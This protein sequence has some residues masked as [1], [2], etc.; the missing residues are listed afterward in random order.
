MIVPFPKGGGR[1]NGKLRVDLTLAEARIA[2][3]SASDPKVISD[4]EAAIRTV[5]K[6][7]VV[8]ALS[9]AIKI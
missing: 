4:L 8:I 7:K 1:L 2:V 3:K 6:G 5:N 9:T